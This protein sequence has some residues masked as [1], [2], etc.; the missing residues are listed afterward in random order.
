MSRGETP[1]PCGNVSRADPGRLRRVVAAGVWSIWLLVCLLGLGA[2]FGYTW[3]E[4]SL[5]YGW[6]WRFAHRQIGDYFPFRFIT[7]WQRWQ[8]WDQPQWVSPLALTGNLLLWLGFTAG[9]TML[10]RRWL[11]SP[12]PWQLTLPRLFLLVGLVAVGTAAWQ[13]AR[14]DQRVLAHL[15]HL[16]RQDLE[17]LR[18]YLPATDVRR[19]LR[20]TAMQR[21]NLCWLRELLGMETLGVPQVVH[22][23]ARSLDPG[24]D[25]QWI[26]RFS[27][28]ESLYI[29][30]PDL[31]PR[32]RKQL[33]ALLQRSRLAPTARQWG[34]LRRLPRLTFLTVEDCNLGSAELAAIAQAKQLEYLA[35]PRNPIT[36]QDLAALAPLQ[37]L[38]HLDLSF[39]RVTDHG[40]LHLLKLPRLELVDLTGTQVTD[41]G[42]ERL[43][44]QGISVV[45]D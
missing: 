6:P 38:K 34:L 42:V 7:Q 37:N 11:S 35:L 40:M 16:H 33:P 12:R 20:I 45:D 30:L 28:L 14:R 43:E 9:G 13:H 15:E 25:L 17:L 36:D 21:R 32:Q 3:G 24:R 18:R 23:S 39:T 27:R 22:Y 44:S 19:S 8:F 10:V 1:H 4:Y 41:G 31:D 26:A 2:V 5:H 29:S